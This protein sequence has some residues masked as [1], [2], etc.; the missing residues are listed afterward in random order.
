MTE[1]HQADEIHLYLDPAGPFSY[2]TTE[3]QTDSATTEG[4][5]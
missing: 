5:H 2:P 1:L 4:N 3:D